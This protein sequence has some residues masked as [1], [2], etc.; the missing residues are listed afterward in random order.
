M[1]RAIYF[2]LWGTLIYDDPDIG[3]QRRLLRVQNAHEALAR[4]GLNHDRADVEAGFIVA[5]LELQKIHAGEVDISARGR[6]VLFLRHVDEDLPDRLDDDGWRLLDD[7][8]LSPALD[9]RPVIMPAAQ[10]TL[11]SIKKRGLPIG[12]ISNAG[13][14]PGFI[15][16]EILEGFGLLRYLDITV[17]SD[18]VELAK[19]SQAIFENA[20][21]ELGVTAAEAAFVGDE[22]VLDVFGS[23]RAG[24]WTVQIGDKPVDGARPHARIDALDQLDAALR[25][26]HL[27]D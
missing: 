24:L 16:R 26:L 4:L 22:P 10:Q 13:A 1:I 18:E 6:T 25:Q 11:A 2:D 8:V 15:L 9:Y 19:P 20:L 7:A 12:L 14:T 27:I 5:A 21:D 17:F 3:E 23:R